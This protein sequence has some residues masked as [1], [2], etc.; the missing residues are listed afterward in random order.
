MIKRRSLIK[1]IMLSPLLFGTNLFSEAKSEKKDTFR[2][3]M[4][5]DLDDDL[6][7]L[8]STPEANTIVDIHQMHNS[9]STF[10]YDGNIYSSEHNPGYIQFSKRYKF[11]E[12]EIYC[13]CLANEMDDAEMPVNKRIRTHYKN[14]K[15]FFNKEV[16]LRDLMPE[17][18]SVPNYPLWFNKGDAPYINRLDINGDTYNYYNLFENTVVQIGLVLPRKG[19]ITVKLF[20]N[21]NEL[22]YSYHETIDLK[23]KYIKS[24]ELK[25]GR[26][27]E[28]PFVEIGNIL[29]KDTENQ[30]E[31]NLYITNMIIEYENKSYNIKL[32]YPAMYPNLISVVS[33]L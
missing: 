5:G 25:S 14:E 30:I 31:N 27:I 7:V 23:P 1:T 24:D 20:R 32:P 29:H 18:N 3:S 26:L 28:D 2:I 22:A 17:Y 12:N 4:F 10:F 19:D 21:D 13:I 6:I 15:L 16:F 11:L 9:K 33:V 8:K